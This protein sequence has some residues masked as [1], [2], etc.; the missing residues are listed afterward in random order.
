MLA[1]S[2][3]AAVTARPIATSRNTQPRYTNSWLLPVSARCS[4]AQVTLW[5][6]NPT[7]RQ[8]AADSIGAAFTPLDLGDLEKV[9]VAAR[10][11]APEALATV[12]LN[13]GAMPLK[14]TL[15]DAGHELIWASQV[16]GHLL[17]LRVLHARGLPGP[18]TRVI[19]VSSEGMYGQRLDLRDR[20]RARGYQRHTHPRAATK[21]PPSD[22]PALVGQVFADTDAWMTTQESP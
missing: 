15:T 1:Q 8:Q 14:R 3:S 13:A 4:T 19:W 9:A 12:V 2:A 10:D 16:L 5:A 11:F 18:E 17:I 20:A 7:R 6:R 22:R 21:S